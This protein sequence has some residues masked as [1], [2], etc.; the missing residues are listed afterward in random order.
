MNCVLVGLR[1]GVCKL[2]R[3]YFKETEKRISLGA[4]EDI[5]RRSRML[6]ISSIWVTL[7][8]YVNDL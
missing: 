1:W 4:L 7:F 3:T 5:N 8:D 2:F 6:T